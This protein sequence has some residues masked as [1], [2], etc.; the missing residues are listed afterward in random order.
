MPLTADQSGPGNRF[1]GPDGKDYDV[2][3]RVSTDRGP[4]VV[5]SHPDA[6]L[7]AGVLVDEG[8]LRDNPDVAYVSTTAE[9]KAKDAADAEA[10]AQAQADADRQA[11][12]QA[13]APATDATDATDVAD[14]GGDSP[15]S[16][17]TP[18]A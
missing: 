11:R 5:V 13:N 1:N 14:N 7:P 10:Q 3:A 2:I 8:H 15:A 16:V 4:F 17:P 12:I 9:A 6:G 18:G